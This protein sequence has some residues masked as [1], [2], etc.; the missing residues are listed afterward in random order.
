MR[1]VSPACDNCGAP[2]RVSATAQQVICGACGARLFVVRAGESVSTRVAAAAG[3]ASI[4]THTSATNRA[5]GNG[6][7]DT[8]P[9]LER[10]GQTGAENSAILD[11]QDLPVK[12]IQEPPAQTQPLLED[13]PEPQPKPAADTLPAIAEK[14]PAGWRRS[15]PHPALSA[16]G[17]FLGVALA[18]AG[19]WLVEAHDTG[20][21]SL[22]LYLT[23]IAIFAASAWFMQPTTSD[24]LPQP[25]SETAPGGAR[26]NRVRA[27]VILVGGAV[28]A[29]MLNVAAAL[30]IKDQ[31][32]SIP[33]I[34]LWLASVLLIGATGIVVGGMFGW[35]PR[36]RGGILPAGRNGRIVLLAVVV[37]ILVVASASRL[38]ALDKIPFGINADEGDRASTSIQIVRGDNTASIFD[39]GWYFIS[40]VY[41]WLLAQLMK[42]IGIGFVQARVFGALASIVSV[43]TIT[44]I[45]IRHFSVRVSLIAGALLSLLALSLQFARETSEAGPTAMLWAIS[46]ALMMEGA[47][48]GRLWAWIGSGLAGGFSLYFYPSARLWAVLAAGFTIYLLI[49]GLGG[50]RLEILRGA[51]FAGV[52]ALMI[53]G[54]F[55]VHTL[56]VFGP[57]GQLDIFSVRAQETSIF[58][59]DNPTRLSYYDP[60]WNS[61]QLVAAQVDHSVGMFNQ[62][63]DDG[64]FW[65]TDRPAMWGL[66]TILT[67]LGVGWV[68]TRWRDP[69]YVLLALWFWTGLAGVIVTVETPNMQRFAAAVPALALFPALVLDSLALRVEAFFADKRWADKLRV[70]W[71]TSG[72]IAAVTLFLVWTQYDFYFNVY[73]NS[74]RWP[75]PTIQ[76]DSVNDQGTDTLVVSVAR[77]YHQVNSG[78][79]R[80]LAPYT[81][82]GGDRN[83]GLDI[84]LAVPAD[85][86]L[87]YILYPNQTPYL[88]YLSSIYAGGTTI[89]YTTTSE[90]LVVD[91]YRIPQDKWSA[92][93]GALAYVGQNSAVKVATLGE[94]PPG[95]TA[96]PATIRWTAGLRVSS[97]WNYE[98]RA[99]GGPARLTIDGVQVLDSA[100]G[101]GAQATMS[102]AMGLHDVEYQA[103]LNDASQ[104]A[105][106]EWAAQPEVKPDASSA[107]PAWAT[108][109]SE[110]LYSGM[111]GPQ[112][113]F[114][115][116]QP[117]DGDNQLPEERRLDGTLAFC[118]PTDL[119]D[120]AAKPFTATWTGTLTAPA[121]GVYSMTL[122]T[123]GALDLKIDGQKVMHADGSSDTTLESSPNLTAGPHSVEVDL[124]VKGGP[125]GL[126][127]IWTPPGGETS[128]VPPSVLSPPKHAGIGSEVP[129]SALGHPNEQ[130]A[131]ASPLETVP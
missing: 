101:T 97:Y 119:T 13:Q 14:R 127:W 24:A 55:L 98:F 28:L 7:A 116:L 50:R 54:P 115:V 120:I 37:I 59:A 5:R 68:S 85:K 96:F 122:F 40:N 18:A 80:L 94:V 104:T 90:G 78:W 105:K 45:G 113:L 36:W 99:P 86:N 38:I 123:Q 29:I 63:H 26:T 108:P 125:G 11:S 77:E 52:A 42:I 47:R 43:A 72:A 31:L 6:Q 81:P 83:P 114:G 70:S 110:D 84:P 64:G 46:I 15:K 121:T 67:L 32:D 61:L 12:N 91:I 4:G 51:A 16:A 25:S 89:P 124:E 66:L 107:Q 92:T 109:A 130:P 2:L 34:Y 100:G 131:N 8:N 112:G 88:P 126:E 74:D 17:G 27:W 48:T 60:S 35:S 30:M 79:V 71:L 49:H 103:T 128:I 65:P 21:L 41:F 22:V 62:Y 106:L 1:S 10:N 39:S 23:G 111:A 53:A 82:R 69:R 57:P 44:W 117:H 58:N 19:E 102:L 20:Q 9:L 75:Q 129:Q 3:Q 95:V 56:P 76:G 87:S 73:G 118:C 93:Q 33:G